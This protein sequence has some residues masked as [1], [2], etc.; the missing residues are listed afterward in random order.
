MNKQR[1]IISVN[2]QTCKTPDTLSL[3][4]VGDVA[5][6]PW[7]DISKLEL[8]NREATDGAEATNQKATETNE[9]TVKS[10]DTISE[11]TLHSRS[12]EIP[13]T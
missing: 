4:S 6:L 13:T 1:K 11:C 9:Q 10:A 12:N 3:V 7:S 8:I 5:E 2:L